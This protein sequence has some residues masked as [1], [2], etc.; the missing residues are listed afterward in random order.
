MAEQPFVIVGGGV[1][2]GSAA[3]ALRARGFD[4][5][6]LVIGDE[7]GA[8]VSRPPLSKQVLLGALDPDRARLRPEAFFA[9]RGIE[10]VNAQVGG[11][12]VVSRRL[13]MADGS[14]LGYAKL[15]LATGG[16]ARTLDV[17]GSRV[18]T[19]RTI[20]DAE[21]LRAR[22]SERAS[23]V[24]V[25]AGF[26]GSEVASSAR[27]LGC[28][29]T[30]IEA[31]PQPLA[32][33]LPSSIGEY[34]CRVHRENGVRVEL[35]TA[36]ASTEHASD[37]VRFVLDDGRTVEGDVA[38]VGI[39]MLPNSELAAGAGL[40]TS[41][42]IEVDELCRT[43]H[44]DVY[45]AGDVA[46]AP[47]RLLGRRIRVEHWQNAQHQAAAAA[48]NM[49]GGADEFAEIPWVWSDQ[50]ELNVQIA[51]DPSPSDRIHVVVPFVHDAGLAILERNGV[52]AGAIGVG[53]GEQV[54]AVRRLMATGRAWTAADVRSDDLVGRCAALIETTDDRVPF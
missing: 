30:I 11:L 28:E 7:P 50:Y 34:F 37:G 16:R 41:N 45:A 52:I 32:R 36:I 17:D 26:I 48:G 46:Y 25:G 9:D 5:R 49:L 44:P 19:L 20:A 10:L 42:G 51:G 8:P 22:V 14:V 47:N 43:T 4:G 2:G 18:F 23:I 39:G 15:L 54:Q 6:I 24:V 3:L 1:A 27:K 31:A 53:H 35:G 29:V 13:T 12:D 21:A 33:V 38:V 40:A